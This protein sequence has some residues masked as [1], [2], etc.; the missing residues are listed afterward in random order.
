MFSA[1]LISRIRQET[2][3]FAAS[4]GGDQMIS[5][6][7]TINDRSS[8][9]GICRKFFSGR[10]VYLK[11]EDRNIQVTFLTYEKGLLCLSAPGGFLLSRENIIFT[12]IEKNII[13][14]HATLAKQEESTAF[15]NV[16]MIQII[17]SPRQD[18]R[19]T[20][21]PEKDKIAFATNII[22]DHIIQRSLSS[23]KGKIETIRNSLSLR[24]Q[25]PFDCLKISFADTGYEDPRMQFFLRKGKIL[26]IPTINPSVKDD[27]EKMLDYY[28]G[29]IRNTD[30]F[31]KNNPQLISEISVPMLMHSKIP[32]GYIQANDRVPFHRNMVPIIKKIARHVEDLSMKSGIL[33]ACETPVPVTDISRNGLG[34][35]F[36]EKALLDYYRQNSYVALDIILPKTKKASILADV[37]HIDIMDNSIIKVGFQIRDMD[38]TS[39]ENFDR[40][41]RA[42]KF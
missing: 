23:E 11:H 5:E 2:D 22:S 39:R 31:L 20:I 34:I 16:S 29:N 33:A 35:V 38:E 32:Y 26:F 40:F 6:V 3:D 18:A 36:R 8:F 4:A 14:A 17:S 12:R 42:L 15:F 10:A 37:R 19:E 27:R 21:I 13:C 25:L 7:Q 41:L 30:K 28:L 9:E 24:E 1:D